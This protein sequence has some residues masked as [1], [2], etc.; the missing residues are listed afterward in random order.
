M[1]ILGVWSRANASAA[2]VMQHKDMDDTLV[3]AGYRRQCYDQDA[4][5]TIIF[6]APNAIKHSYPLSDPLFSAIFYVDLGSY[7][8]ANLSYF[9]ADE[10]VS[11]MAC[12]D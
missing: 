3:A 6:L 8:G 1:W 7:N 10:Y 9:T 2:L 12:A 11:R 4:D 5:L